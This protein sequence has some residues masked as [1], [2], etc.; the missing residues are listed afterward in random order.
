MLYRSEDLHKD[1]QARKEGKEEM[2]SLT[3]FSGQKK[4]QFISAF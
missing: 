3:N 2:H 4:P 1:I